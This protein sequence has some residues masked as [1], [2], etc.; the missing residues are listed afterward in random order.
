AVLLSRPRQQDGRGRLL[1][2]GSPRPVRVVPCGHE[3]EGGG[4]DLARGSGKRHARC[5]LDHRQPAEVV[6]AMKKKVVYVIAGVIGLAALA[7]AVKLA[8]FDARPTVDDGK[9]DKQRVANR[10]VELPTGGYVGS[11]TCRECHKSQHG[12]WHDSYHRTMTQAASK[13]SV[14][15]DFDDV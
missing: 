12:A 13:N 9:P 2:A 1:H 6:T 14:V 4:R 15:G 10:P 7:V 3:P 11:A 5:H 8:W